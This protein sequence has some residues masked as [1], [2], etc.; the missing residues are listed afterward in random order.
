MHK[1]FNKE[2]NAS[3]SY[4]YRKIVIQLA[5][6]LQINKRQFQMIEFLYKK[7]KIAEKKNN[8]SIKNTN[9]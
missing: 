6:E 2:I 8:K 9:Q 3:K 7:K 4:F 5:I 1:F